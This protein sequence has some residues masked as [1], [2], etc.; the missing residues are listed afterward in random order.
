M[1]PGEDFSMNRKEFLKKFMQ[2]GAGVCC[3]GAMLGQTLLAQEG[4]SPST[5]IPKARDWIGDMEK[6]MIAGSETPAWKKHEKALEWIKALLNSMDKTIDPQTSMAL[7]QAN[8]RA[9]YNGAFG[10]AS[11]EPPDPA[12]IERFMGWIESNYQVTQE[13]GFRWFHFSWG[14]NHQNPQGLIMRDGFCMCPIVESI[15]PG[16]SPTYCNCSAGYVGEIFR[17][18][19]GRPVNVSIV[20]TV[21]MGGKDCIFRV[22][23]PDA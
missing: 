18:G 21:Q 13:A 14:E 17:R 12:S 20:E 19:L 5:K 10:V 3:C 7:M 15:V 8:G 23:I 1:I 6:R 2:T 9:C 4:T 11:D 22:E 16:L